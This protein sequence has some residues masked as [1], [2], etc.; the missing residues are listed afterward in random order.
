MNRINTL[1]LRIAIRSLTSV[2]LMI[3]FGAALVLGAQA[4]AFGNEPPPSSYWEVDQIR[5][6]MKGVGKTVMVGTTIVDFEA[7]VLGVMRNVSPGR[8]M[9]LCRLSGSGLEHAGIIQGMSGSPI[10]VDGKLMGAVAFA[11]E[12][13]KDPIAGVTPFAQMVQYARSSDRRLAAELKE[14]RQRRSTKPGFAPGSASIG[15]FSILEP[16]DADATT[17][18][19]LGPRSKKSVGGMIPIVTPIATSG[20]GALGMATLRS[21]LSPVGMTPMPSG[22]ALEEIIVREGNKPL[23]PGSPLSVGLVIGDFDVSGIGTVTHVEGDRV[24]GFGHPMMELG[25]CELPMMSGYIHTVYPRSSVSMKMGSPLKMIGVIDTDVSTGIA[26][27]LGGSIDLLPMTVRVKVGTYAEPSIYRVQVVREPSLIAGLV[28]SVL[29]NAVDTEGSLPDE[30]TA[31]LEATLELEGREPILIRD[32]LSG[33]RY[34]GPFG[35]SSLFNPIT[36]T[37]R[38][39]A[40]NPLEPVRIERIDVDLR[41]DQ[42]HQFAELDSV[43][44]LKKGVAPGKALE[45]VARLRHRDGTFGS[46]TI[47]MELPSDFPEGQ[48]QATLMGGTESLKRRFQ[49]D[50]TLGSPGTVD[51][52]LRSI[53]LQTSIRHDRLYLHVRHPGNSLAVAGEALLELPESALALFDDPRVLPSKPMRFDLLATTDTTDVIEGSVRVDF[54][55]IAKSESLRGD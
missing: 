53:R 49:N 55:I 52:L 24:Y 32:R 26:G 2:L 22:S 46:E 30:L 3:G 36:R 33:P 4:Q 35:I 54:E 14:H 7:E 21:E 25:S 16:P 19:G 5:P 43:R 44:L 42:S 39:L 28:S 47:R 50:P 13:A 20:F 51:G 18:A 8:D 6:G 34:V 41:I 48:Y 11:W 9:I 31:E 1:R 37:V 15:S 45:L 17:A 29:A 12:F 23:Q 38:I 10:Y 27:R 40:N